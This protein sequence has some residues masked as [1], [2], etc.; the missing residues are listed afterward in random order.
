MLIFSNFHCQRENF[1]AHCLRFLFKRGKFLFRS[2]AQSWDT[3]KALLSICC[4]LYSNCGTS[5][6]KILLQ[7][8]PF[9]INFAKALFSYYEHKTPSF[10]IQQKSTDEKTRFIFFFSFENKKGDKN[11]KNSA[12]DENYFL[13]LSFYIFFCCNI[14]ERRKKLNTWRREGGKILLLNFWCPLFSH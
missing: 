7:L 14:S 12:R 5:F 1:Y 4:V 2:F 6:I 9:F 10:N 3:Y 8:F 11:W 13:L